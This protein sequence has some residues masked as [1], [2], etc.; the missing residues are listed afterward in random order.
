MLDD[1]EGWLVQ[2]AT[3]NNLKFT[4]KSQFDQR[5]AGGNAKQ[6]PAQIRQFKTQIEQKKEQIAE[7]ERSGNT[8]RATAL[9]DQLKK[10]RKDAK[11]MGALTPEDDD[12]SLASASE[13]PAAEVASDVPSTWNST[14]VINETYLRSVSRFPTADELQ[15]A[16]TYIADSADP[17]GGV[18]DV[19]WALMNTRE[20]IVNH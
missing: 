1:A 20:F 19:L 2:V 11:R 7:A 16:Q 3:E 13:S 12:E 4:R 5:D 17:I 18:R 10:I 8:K 9:T 15:T 6:K 14:D